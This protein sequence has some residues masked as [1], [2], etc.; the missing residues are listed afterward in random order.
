MWRIE[1]EQL[2]VDTVR[3]HVV[4][5]TRAQAS[6][7]DVLALLESDETFVEAWSLAFRQA[8]MQAYCWECPALLLETVGRPFECVLIDSPM[9]F[10]TRP[11]PETFAEHF[12][13]DRD[14]VVFP[15]LG[16]DATLVAPCPQGGR[17]FA[18]L[19]T[20]MR[21]AD[22]AQVRAFWRQ[23]SVVSRAALAD[24]PIWL[25]TAGLGVSWLHVRLDTRPKYYRHAPYKRVENQL[26]AIL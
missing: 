1:S 10:G 21:S 5:A 17:D 12:R 11:E 6:F 15:S 26:R 18:H 4:I 16:R 22:W 3:W 2:R 14:V 9:L 20:F 24:V 19:A 13:S 25:S 23:V 7:D 8:P